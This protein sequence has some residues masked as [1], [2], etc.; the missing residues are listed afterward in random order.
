V[1]CAGPFQHPDWLL[2]WWRHIGRGELFVLAIHDGADLVG[3]APFYIHSDV[4][5]AT[6]QLTLLGNGV[7]DTCDVLLDPS[8]AGAERALAERLLNPRG[9]WNACDLRDLPAHSRLIP[10]VGRANGASLQDDQPCVVLALSE[11]AHGADPLPARIRM[12]L[13]RRHRRAEELGPVRLELAGPQDVVP[14]LEAVFDL[15]AARWRARGERGIFDRSDVTAFH[16]EVAE[17]FA[18]RHWLRLHRFHV[19]DRLAAANYGFCV[20]RRAYSYVGG[21]DPDFAKLGAGGLMLH[22]IIRAAADEGAREFDLLRGEEGYKL[23]WGGQPRR[24]YRLTLRHDPE[25][26]AAVF[27]KDHAQSRS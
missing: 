19:G 21:F 9:C 12:D 4:T 22:R 27:R 13:R 20:R 23:R 17:R 18:R 5:T 11:W 25:Q 2:A 3:L 10:T 16:R 8:H 14:A 15:H 24:Q 6:R 1:A 26:C 7:S